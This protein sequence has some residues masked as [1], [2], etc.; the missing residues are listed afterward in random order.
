MLLRKNICAPVAKLQVVAYIEG[1]P[2]PEYIVGAMTTWTE[3]ATT[4]AEAKTAARSAG[5]GATAEAEFA[6]TA[7]VMWRQ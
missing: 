2:P 4:A 1:K 3:T 5:T 6:T 7:V